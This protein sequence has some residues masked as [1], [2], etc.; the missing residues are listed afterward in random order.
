M[1]ITRKW[2]LKMFIVILL[3]SNFH[4]HFMTNHYKQKMILYNFLFF[5]S[6]IVLSLSI[7]SG[8]YNLSTGV[9]FYR[10]ILT[11]KTF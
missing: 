6:K 1:L 10:L 9:A 2:V 11:D 4:F 3:L 8:K 5:S 7:L